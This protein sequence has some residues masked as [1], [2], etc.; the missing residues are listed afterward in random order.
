MLSDSEG[1]DVRGS[2]PVKRVVRS[3]KK[4]RVRPEVRER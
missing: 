4:R 3:A 2:V 1:V